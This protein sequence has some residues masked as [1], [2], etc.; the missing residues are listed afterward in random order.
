MRFDYFYGEADAEQFAFYRIP[1]RLITGEEFQGISTDTKLL[2]GLMLDRLQLSIRNKWLDSLNRVYIIYT[3][4]DIM[5]DM[6]CG[7]Q[8]AVKMLAELEND[9]GLIKRKRQGLGKPSLIYVL[10]FSTNDPQKSSE[11]HFKKCEKHT[12][13]DVKST[14]QEVWKSHS[15]KTDSN[16]TEFNKTNLIYPSAKEQEELS[17]PEKEMD[18]MDGEKEDPLSVRKSY[19]DYFKNHLEYDN[20]LLKYPYDHGRINE[21]I[22]VLVD[23][24]CGNAVTIRIGGEDRPAE[25]VKSRFMK[26]DSSH[27]E[28]ILDCFHDNTTEIRNIRSY[29]LTMLYNAPFTIDHYYQAKVNHDMYGY[30]RE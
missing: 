28:Y 25:V 2:Y 5:A 15:N 11:S 9:A 24:V 14:R 17:H 12:S 7:N 18:S 4:E 29:M 16:Q 30:D 22:D 1:K 21:I 20:L 19:E 8:K 10:K 26:L 6:H 27:I 13:G 23:T 3:V